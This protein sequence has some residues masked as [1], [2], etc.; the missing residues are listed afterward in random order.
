MSIKPHFFAALAPVLLSTASEASMSDQVIS[1]EILDNRITAC[2]VSIDDGQMATLRPFIETS[3]NI[4]GIF[5]VSVTKRSVSGTSMMNQDNA[6]SAGSL[7]NVRLV[8]D[9]PSKLS[10]QMIVNDADGRALCRL[11]AEI[12][13]KPAEVRT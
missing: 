4:S 13:L 11:A 12:D 10:I 8:V 6:F 1:G 9:R 3:A 7:G 2:G 5:R